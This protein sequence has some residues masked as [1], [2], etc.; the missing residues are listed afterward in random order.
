[1][2]FPAPDLQLSDITWDALR[3]G[4]KVLVATADHCL[5]ASTLTRA[6]W[7]WHAAGILLACAMGETAWSV[8]TRNGRERSRNEDRQ[9]TGELSDTTEPEC[10]SV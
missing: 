6:L 8:N 5:Q 10:I 1:M 3:E 9:N 4:M 7:A 2:I